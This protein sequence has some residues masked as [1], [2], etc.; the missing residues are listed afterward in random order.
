M[1]T[2]K[3]ILYFAIFKYPLTKAEIYKFSN[4]TSKKQLDFELATLIS[5]GIIFKHKDFY[6]NIDDPLLVPR[7]LKGNKMAQKIMPMAQKMGKKI[8]QF[9]FVKSVSVSGSISKGYYDEDSGDIDFFII[10]APNK[11]WIARSFLILYK[12]IFLLNSKKYFCVNYFISSNNL[13]IQEQNRFTATE[14]ATLIPIYGQDVFNAFIK[15]NIWVKN[16][17]PNN[18]GNA[19]PENNTLKKNLLSR[20]IELCCNTSVGNVFDDVLRRITLKRWHTKFDTFNKE[21]FKIAM[22]STKD[23]SKHH[24]QN[25]QKKVIDKLNLDY[26]KLNKKYSLDIN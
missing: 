9:P 24:P 26:S 6:T 1:N 7:R 14:V 8:A 12:K 19:Y 17:F 15:K 10:T 16:Y 22:K 4:I 3:T 2:L 18:N 5:K 21:D 23:V 11:L 25:F 20:A 13:E